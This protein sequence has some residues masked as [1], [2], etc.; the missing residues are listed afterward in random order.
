MMVAEEVLQKL[1]NIN[2]HTRQST[3][4]RNDPE[5]F[6]RE[7]LK[8][9][10]QAGIHEALPPEHIE[11]LAAEYW[12]LPLAR[13]SK[14]AYPLNIM[15]IAAQRR[16]HRLVLKLLRH[17]TDTVRIQAAE[18]FQIMFAMLDGYYDEASSLVNQ[19]LLIPT[20][21]PEVKYALL[22]DAGRSSRHGLPR[23]ISDAARRLI[24]DLD[25]GVSYH[26][27]RLLSYLH[28]VRDWR[29]VLDR[30]ITLVG[31]EDEASEYFLAAGIE[32]LEVIIPHESAVVD[33]IKS[34][35]EAYPPEHLALR[36]VQTYVRANPDV[37]L[38]VGLISRR[39]YRELTGA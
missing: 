34:L 9:A 7:V 6:V 22:R 1:E 16:N 20:E 2:N 37:A 4:L 14:A 36:A 39:D 28:D 8:Q 10:K 38:Q 23:E 31:E 25:Q 3:K 30:M 19:I 27:L 12:L 32:Y 17:P 35:V 13:S 5:G 15:E 18:Q 29:A 24:H 26:S 21:I 11:G 33:W